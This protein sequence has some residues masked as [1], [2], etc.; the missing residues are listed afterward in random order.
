[1]CQNRENNDVLLMTDR[2]GDRQP[3]NLEFSNPRKQ[4][5]K[6]KDRKR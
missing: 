6:R 1:M 4:E 2:G 3:H 5:T